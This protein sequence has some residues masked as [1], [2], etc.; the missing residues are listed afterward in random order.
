MLSYWAYSCKPLEPEFHFAWPSTMPQ[1]RWSQTSSTPASETFIPS[2]APLV[3]AFR[4]FA[5][6]RACRSL[7]HG[8]ETP[9]DTLRST[10][11][12]PH[13]TDL[14]I[15]KEEK[16]LQEN[17]TGLAAS[18]WVNLL[19]VGPACM[20]VGFGGRRLVAVPPVFRNSKQYDLKTIFG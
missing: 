20:C 7:E 8:C 6:A 4:A 18:L 15:S 19:Q 11:W 16:D 10:I 14:V 1:S 5:L 2:A 9:E 13:P 12:P 17:P 3:P